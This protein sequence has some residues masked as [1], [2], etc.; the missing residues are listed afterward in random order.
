MAKVILDIPSDNM[1]SFSQAI[2][3]LGIKDNI[4]QSKGSQLSSK[5]IFPTH[6]SQFLLFDWEFFSNE[7]EFE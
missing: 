7:L 3:K 6:L 1:H 5:K 2:V 4:I